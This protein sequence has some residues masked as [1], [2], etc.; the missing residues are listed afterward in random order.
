MNHTTLRSYNH[1]T[2]NNNNNNSSSS[3]SNS[4]SSSNNGGGGGATFVSGYYK[5]S[6]SEITEF[7]KRKQLM[8]KIVASEIVIKECPFCH[9]TKNNVSNMWKLYIHRYTGAYLCHRCGCKGSWYDFKNKVSFGDVDPGSSSSTSTTSSNNT[10]AK[11]MMMSPMI[12]R[13][14]GM[15]AANGNGGNKSK[16][17]SQ[18][19]IEVF[20]KDFSM[21]KYP[22]LNKYIASRGIQ[23]ETCKAYSVGGAYFNFYVQGEND[24]APKNVPQLCVTFPMFKPIYKPTTLAQHM[25]NRES[26]RAKEQ[27]SQGDH[28]SSAASSNAA[29]SSFAYSRPTPDDYQLV[30]HKV[31][32]IGDK[33]LQRLDPTGGQW[34]LFGLS[35]VPDDAKS[36]VLTE[37]E[38]DAMAVF[39][40]T[41]MPAVSLPNG[42][43]SLP[44]DILPFL[45]RFEKIYLWMD[46][47]I[48]GQEGAEQFANKLGIGRCYI[49][50]SSTSTDQLAKMP[51]DANEALLA[52][53]DLKKCL[54]EAAPINHERIMTYNALKSEIFRELYESGVETAGTPSK[55]FPK[56]NRIL[57]GHRRGELTVITGPTGIG[58]TTILSQLTL[59]Y[60]SQ[61]VNTL[62]GSFEIKNHRLAKKMICQLAGKDLSKFRYEFDAYS[63][64]FGRL[65]LYFMS[66][67]GSTDIDQVLDAM[68]YAVYVHDVQHI[69]IDNLQFMMSG[70]GAG[71]EKFDM[72][73]KAIEKLRM[74]ATHKNVHITIVIHP[75]K[76]E[77]GHALGI[78]SVFGTAK[79][80]QEADNVIIIQKGKKYRYLSI[81][82]NRF[83]GSIGEIPY[84]FDRDSTKI[85]ELSDDQVKEVE[86]GKIVL[87]Y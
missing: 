76:V 56:L 47:D 57:K 46:D 24:T 10:S 21:I 77:D 26:Q 16:M 55:Y 17:P 60:C 65:P 19:D 58:K 33:S 11:P 68:D 6:E 34:G 20:Q 15:S 27:S 66:F 81:K 64:Q 22:E 69:I 1:Y 75:R 84:R 13:V 63:E 71:Y 30:R 42:C 53:V 62:W 37:G 85:F 73:D 80:T 36:I 49:V 3:S 29:R 25:R 8:Y 82:K 78:A 18:R 12:Q 54:Q 51:K 31:R 5:V 48:P 35:I 2:N 50:H 32:A 43:R 39:Q 72:Q 40:A 45:E 87:E 86:D 67:Y 4:N 83:D 23:K 52:G 14:D 41:G 61:G 38:F 7:M 70:Q 79:A 59:D 28:H 44:V 9:D 74:F